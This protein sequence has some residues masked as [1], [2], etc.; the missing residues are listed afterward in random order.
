MDLDE[1]ADRER[2]LRWNLQDN[3]GNPIKLCG[4]SKETPLPSNIGQKASPNFN[5]A[6]VLSACDSKMD[7]INPGRDLVSQIS[8]KSNIN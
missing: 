5:A 8:N 4:S 1:E 7:L 2:R 3:E 6:S